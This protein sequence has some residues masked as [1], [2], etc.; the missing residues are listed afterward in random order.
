MSPGWLKKLKHWTQKYQRT[1][2]KCSTNDD[3]DDDDIT[4]TRKE[5]LL[6]TKMAS[7]K[8]VYRKI[9]NESPKIVKQA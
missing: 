4:A 1:L 6:E 7:I 5:C 2:V 3:E 9:N 8:N